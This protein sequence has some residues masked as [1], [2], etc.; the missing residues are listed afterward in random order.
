[1]GRNGWED[2]ESVITNYHFLPLPWKIASVI[3]ERVEQEL[4]GGVSLYLF[5]ER[6]E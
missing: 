3:T 4:M 1:M 2:E 5:L 6:A